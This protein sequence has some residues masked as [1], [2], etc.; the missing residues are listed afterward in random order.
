M[1]ESYRR[2][3][4]ANPNL[5][6]TSANAYIRKLNP[7]IPSRIKYTGIRVIPDP[8]TPAEYTPKTA[9][10]SIGCSYTTIPPSTPETPIA[11]L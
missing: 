10:Y 1:I 5:A 8:P 7:H 9:S 3:A 11:S 4:S 2:L 6:I